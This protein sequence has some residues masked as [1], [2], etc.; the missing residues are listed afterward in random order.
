MSQY[1]AF[2]FVPRPAFEILNFNN[3]E[4]ILFAKDNHI[5]RYI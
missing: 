4:Q 1:L 3:W 5:I 2:F